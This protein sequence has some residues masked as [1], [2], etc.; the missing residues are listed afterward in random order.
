LQRRTPQARRGEAWWAAAQPFLASDCPVMAPRWCQAPVNSPVINTSSP[1]GALQRARSVQ[2]TSAAT[3]PPRVVARPWRSLAGQGAGSRRASE[4]PCD[5]KKRFLA[6]GRKW[7][8]SKEG[9]P[10]VLGPKKAPA[11]CQGPFGSRALAGGSAPPEP[12]VKSRHVGQLLRTAHVR[13][14][15]VDDG[16]LAV[17]RRRACAAAAAAA[18]TFPRKAGHATP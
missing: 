16:L 15:D 1:C 4:Q 13:H 12:C 9:G 18:P 3:M 7:C 17:V 14:G 5:P 2:G 11:W 6:G 10:I 8:D